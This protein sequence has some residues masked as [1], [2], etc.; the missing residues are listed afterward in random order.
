M[1]YTNHQ[2]CILT[3]SWAA[4]GA[5]VLSP[6]SGLAVTVRR[7]LGQQDNL[8]PFAVRFSQVCI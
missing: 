1:R 4:P 5:A 3:P 2:S 7:F 6:G 8:V